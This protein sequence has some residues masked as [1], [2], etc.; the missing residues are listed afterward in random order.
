MALPNREKKMHTASVSTPSP[1]TPAAVTPTL[2]PLSPEQKELE[3]EAS[4]GN[5]QA[6]EKLANLYFNRHELALC[7]KWGSEARRFFDEEYKKNS[8]VVRGLVK[9]MKS[10]LEEKCKGIE[11]SPDPSSHSYYF[12]IIGQYYLEQGDQK[13]GWIWLNRGIKLNDCSSLAYAAQVYA[14]GKYGTPENLE[15][16][17]TLRDTAAQLGHMPSHY[18][19]YLTVSRKA[20]EFK[21]MEAKSNKTLLASKAK[22]AKPKPTAYLFNCAFAS[23]KKGYIE[24]IALLGKLQLECIDDEE[25]SIKKADADKLEEA[26]FHQELFVRHGL[27]LRKDQAYEKLLFGMENGQY[28]YLSYKLPFREE[29][30]EFCLATLKKN[31]NSENPNSEAERLLAC[32]HFCKKEYKEAQE[33]L[34]RSLKHPEWP[35]YEHWTLQYLLHICAGYVVEHSQA[36]KWAK[37]LAYQYNDPAGWNYLGVLHYCM[38]GIPKDEN[39]NKLV[40]KKESQEE[41][42]KYWM[43]AKALDHPSAIENLQKVQKNRRFFVWKPDHLVWPTYNPSLGDNVGWKAYYL[44]RSKKTLLKIMRY[45]PEDIKKLEKDKF[46]AVTHRKDEMKSEK[47]AAENRT[48]KKKKRDA[49]DKRRRADAAEAKERESTMLTAAAAPPPP[50]PASTPPASAASAVGAPPASA[51]SA[52]TTPSPIFF[53]SPSASGKVSAREEL[54]ALSSLV[55]LARELIDKLKFIGLYEG[56]DCSLWGVYDMRLSPTEKH[57]QELMAMPEQA[58]NEPTDTQA[59][60]NLKKYKGKFKFVTAERADF[61]NNLITQ[62]ASTLDKHQKEKILL[63]NLNVPESKIEENTELTNDQ[64]PSMPAWLFLSAQDLKTKAEMLSEPEEGPAAPVWKKPPPKATLG[65]FFAPVAA[66]RTQRHEMTGVLLERIIDKECKDHLS[67]GLKIDAIFHILLNWFEDLPNYKFG[68]LDLEPLRNAIVHREG[69]FPGIDVLETLGETINSKNERALN[70]LNL[71]FTN[72]I[73]T[74]SEFLK[75][76]NKTSKENLIK[77][78]FYMQAMAQGS[79]NPYGKETLSE[80]I[81]QKGR[82]YKEK[83]E[84]LAKNDALLNEMLHHAEETVRSRAYIYDPKKMML[85]TLLNRETVLD[86]RHHNDRDTIVIAPKGIAPT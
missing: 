43:N 40:R 70:N 65:K 72:F 69:L 73:R 26:K 52:G 22:A 75:N 50:P 46:S 35:L 29:D 21:E 41:A 25:Q 48:K 17:L 54:Q 15:E 19:G 33:L 31:V 74:F 10:K 7:V 18:A 4:A 78:P 28:N 20:P 79:E 51:A 24:G 67:I 53:K 66:T 34:E 1:A 77:D 62:I 64:E 42:V 11:T 59:K 32:T 60:N 37:R 2:P 47:K 63:K 49:I 36:Y 5:W 76:P 3:K 12:Q 38:L 58:D 44:S 83:F 71:V 8:R 82:V 14:E 45:E 55:V 84:E 6:C 16:A 9:T 23:A 27:P 39:D 13:E 57:V 68:N 30:L 85:D 61:V 81:A 86:E 80:A 56:G